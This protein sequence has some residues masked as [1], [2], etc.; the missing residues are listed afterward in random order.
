M[1]L[2]PSPDL[3]AFPVELATNQ[4]IGDVLLD[5][6]ICLICNNAVWKA[7]ECGKCAKLFCK[8]CIE[9]WLHRNSTCPACR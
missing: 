2:P 8:N 9:N 1:I 5:D 4:K 7:K 6:C 3:D